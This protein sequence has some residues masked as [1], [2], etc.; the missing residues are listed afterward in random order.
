MTILS[1]DQATHLGYAVWEE[2]KIK[3]YGC[4]NFTI[5]KDNPDKKLK[6]IREFVDKLIQEYQPT[7]VVIEGVQFQSNYNTY[8]Q[9]CKLQGVLIELCIEREQLYEVIPT[10]KWKT[11]G[12]KGKKRAEQKA[13]SI[14]FVRE[15]FGLSVN[16]DVA[17]AINMG[18]YALNNIKVKG[19]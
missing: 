8:A 7:L 12:I 16:D 19:E 1:I 2:G 14:Q 3:K 15:N 5:K 18:Y 11:I 9:L 13:S 4:K 10:L 6:N 17:D